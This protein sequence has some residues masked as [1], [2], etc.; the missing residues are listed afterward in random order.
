MYP[1]D[2]VLGNILCVTF[3]CDPN[4]DASKQDKFCEWSMAAGLG[5]GMMAAGSAGRIFD[6]GMLMVGAGLG[7]IPALL[8]QPVVD[9]IL[10][11]APQWTH[12]IHYFCFAALGA[13]VA[14]LR[15]DYFIIS[16]SSVFGAM[17]WGMAVSYFADAGFTPTAISNGT[18]ASDAKSIGIAAAA[19][20]LAVMGFV[21]QGK[22]KQRRDAR[23]NGGM[24]ADLLEDA[25]AEQRVLIDQIKSREVREEAMSRELARAGGDKRTFCHSCGA[26]VHPA[27]TFCNACGE[28]VTA[29]TAGKA[30]ASSP[31]SKLEGVV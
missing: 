7:L 12:Y 27:G 15:P 16:F 6:A 11:D 24:A 28:A 30:E 25:V 18:T 26:K 10:A 31:S 8:L 4:I 1:V 22:M 13:G 9:Q 23:D 21:F 2:A 14:K 5:V 29:T 3:E 17:V 19:S 20:V